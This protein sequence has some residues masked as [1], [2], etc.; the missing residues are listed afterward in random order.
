MEMQEKSLD[1]SQ[2][3]AYLI[4]AHK[5]D[6]CFRTLLRMLDDPRNEIFLHMDRKNTQYDAEAVEQSM[7][8]S[9]VVHVPR[10]S[11]SWGSYSLVHAELLLLKEATAAGHYQHYHLLSGADLPIQT[12]DEIHR[13]FL[14]NQD[15]E[16]IQFERETFGCPERVRYYYPLME[17][18]GRNT[19]LLY[20]ASGKALLLLQKALHVHRN[21]GIRF[22]KGSNWFSITDALAR[23]VVA[24]EP[25]IQ[26]TFR[27]TFCSDELFLQT[28]VLN[29]P[30]VHHLYDD[31]FDRG[32]GA[33]ARFIDWE[34][35]TPYVFR[36]SDFDELVQSD[37]MFA[38]KF[39]G[40]VDAE[41]I[42]AIE[43][44]FQ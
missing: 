12:Q 43:Q 1:A 41:I 6:L 29:S 3:Q 44:K 39:D 17:L 5:E 16:F 24:R 9:R 13:F 11:V 19:G 18:T 40:A 26:K 33:A 35:G 15:K 20:R 2:K 32:C 10:I 30:F 7:K 28:V 4:L 38:R 36:M 23:Y 27:S 8:Y 14:Q 34:R 37:L 21:R 25:W 22:Q 31:R 42:R